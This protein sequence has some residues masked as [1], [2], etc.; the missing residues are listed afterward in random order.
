MGK[1]LLLVLFLTIPTLC[2]SGSSFLNYYNNPNNWDSK[3]VGE[4]TL[5]IT[6]TLITSQKYIL[7]NNIELKLIKNG[8]L[9][10]NY[11][12]SLTGDPNNLGEYD[13]KVIY[14]NKVLLIITNLLFK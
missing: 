10:S 3:I 7:P 14:S 4:G 2:F 1:K 6:T 9:I 8:E 11:D 5:F 13:P 12:F